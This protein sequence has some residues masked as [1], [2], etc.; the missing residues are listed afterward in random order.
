LALLSDILGL[1][2]Q[3]I[4][5]VTGGGSASVG[6]AFT[7]AGNTVTVGGNVIAT[8]PDATAATKL[9]KALTALVVGE[10]SAVK[11]AVIGKVIDLLE[12]L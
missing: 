11:A 9:A 10:V 7:V 5:G 6:V 2:D 3:V 12:K 1:L 4:G 8:L